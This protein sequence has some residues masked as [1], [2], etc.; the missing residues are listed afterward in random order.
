MS[1][2]R[3]PKLKISRRLGSITRI[4]NEKNQIKLNRPGKDGN[5]NADTSKKLTEYAMYV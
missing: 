4:N 3:G 2:Y 5:A 1:R